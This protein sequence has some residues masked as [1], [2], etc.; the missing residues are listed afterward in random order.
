MLRRSSLCFFLDVP[1][2]LQ[3]LSSL[4]R[5][6]PRPWQ[7]KPR[8]LTIEWPGSS[9]KEVLIQLLIVSDAGKD[10]R[11]EEKGTTEEMVG[12]HHQLNGHESEQTPGDTEGQGSLACCSP[13]GRDELDTT[14][15]LN[16]I[17]LMLLFCFLKPR[18]VEWL[19]CRE[20][21]WVVCLGRWWW[22]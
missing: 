4:T 10:W 2:G 16:W 22:R 19:G 15:Q 18:L 5:N 8:I 13:W 7:W 14:E 20:F 12:W 11:Q 9:H 6:E 3:D 21:D 1:H 17:E